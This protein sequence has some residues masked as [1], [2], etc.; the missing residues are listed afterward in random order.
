MFKK[1]IAFAAMLALASPALAGDRTITPVPSEGQTIRYDRGVPTIE[2]DMA[3]SA[4]KVVPLPTQDHGS[5]Q[6][7]IAV[8]NKAA[9]RTG[10]F[11]VENIRVTRADGSVVDV[12]TRER[13]QAKAKN[14]AMWSQ[15]GM[16]ALAGVA[17]ASQN[18]DTHID[19]YSRYGSSHTV[20]SRPGLSAGQVATIGA[21]GVGI[22][23]SQARLEQ[24]LAQLSDEIVQ[25]TTIDP[26]GSYGGR[27]VID[28]LKNQ[29]GAER[30]AVDVEFNGEHHLFA[31]DASK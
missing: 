2:T 17:A 8:Y 10:N 14:R 23:L 12:F 27:I 26:D 18:N 22:A 4:V 13:L 11:G 9:S 16:A 30:L 25:T 29:K 1:I 20:I 6:F 15:I 21:G 28:K 7:M 19:T 31:F 5:F 3:S 24:T